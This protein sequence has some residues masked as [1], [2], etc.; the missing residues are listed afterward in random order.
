MPFEFATATRIIF[1]NGVVQQAASLIAE[2][3][4]RVFLVSGKS[5]QRCEFLTKQLSALGIE[6]ISFGVNGEPTVD[7]V[8]SA[9]EQARN[10]QCDVVVGFGGGSVLDTGKV[11]AAMLTNSGDLFDY[12][13][14]VG[15]GQPLALPS[16]PLVAI[17]TTAGTG[18]EVTR[19]SVLDVP[20][21]RVKVSM[22][23]PYM[24]PKVAI[25][26]PEL[27]HSMSPQLTAA[28]GL[29]ALTQVLEPYVSNKANPLTDS[30]CREGLQRAARSLLKAY[31]NGSD[32]QAREDMSLVNLFGGLALANAKLG[33]VHGFA[34]PLGGMFSAPHGALCARILPL[35]FEQNV[36][37]L[38]ER[39]PDSPY[40][41]R[42]AEVA[43]ILTDNPLATLEEGVQWLQQ[44]CNK[45][46]VSPLRDYGM[47]SSDIPAV[48]LKSKNSSS[49]KGNPI[50]LTDQELAHI[51]TQAL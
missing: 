6:T 48:V 20:E 21:H 38:Q 37:A 4:K 31:E 29:D 12:L 13:E 8:K 40:L 39:A 33:A 27:T 28:T 11:I 47:S 45:L 34:G 44:L 42:F 14:V 30:L 23:S 1:G 50:E 18:A 25:V 7:L 15:K 17:T 9:V 10:A 41:K 19:N 3:G 24:L 5:A 2:L 16:A 32:A 36:A 43:Q 51:L 26:D 46:Q 49:M 22:R 35:A